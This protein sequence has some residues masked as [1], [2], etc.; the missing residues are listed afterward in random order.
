MAHGIG[1]DQ[2][3]ETPIKAASGC[4]WRRDAAVGMEEA[5]EGL[6]TDRD[7]VKKPD[8]SSTE[9]VLGAAEGSIRPAGSTVLL[10][11]ETVGM[12]TPQSKPYQ[13]GT[14]VLSHLL[15]TQG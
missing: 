3:S 5:S 11:L 10:S 4:H 14:E 13:L 1:R 2:L 9:G 7:M 12:A 6:R 15:L 8:I